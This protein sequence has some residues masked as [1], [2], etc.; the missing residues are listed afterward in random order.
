MSQLNLG[1]NEIE[2]MP[3]EFTEWFYKRKL[4]DIIDEQ[5]ARKGGTIPM[6]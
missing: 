4:Q 2:N 3:L 5:E 6:F 1:Y